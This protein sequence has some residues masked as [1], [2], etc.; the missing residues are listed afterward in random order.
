VQLSCCLRL[1]RWVLLV[2]L[3][4]P[5]ALT[6]QWRWAATLT[7]SLLRVH[8]QQAEQQ[9]LLLHL[10]LLLVVASLLLQAPAVAA[11]ELPQS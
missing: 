7:L 3:L 1:H 9:D 5:L 4:L 10:L 8:C 2:C 11:A 6:G